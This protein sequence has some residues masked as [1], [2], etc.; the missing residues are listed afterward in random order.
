MSLQALSLPDMAG[1]AVGFLLTVSIFSYLFRDNA[2]FR[3]AI[4]LFIGVAAGLAAAI[5]LY[6]V[7][8]PRLI[9][10]LWSAKGDLQD[11]LLLLAPVVLVIL[12][13]MKTSIRTSAWGSPVMAF[14]TGVG[15]A[16]A[17]G[18]AVLG[19]L[20]PQA[21]A[22]INVF[23]AQN[24]QLG[25]PGAWHEYLTAI[26]LLVVTIATLI[27]FQFGWRPVLHQ[28]ARE[29]TWV[30]GLTWVGKVTISVTL[31]VIFAGILIAS[32]SGLVER[33]DFLLST[34]LSLIGL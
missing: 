21:A 8:W 32:M 2:L 7:I 28:E 17:V 10:P 25:L 6:N 26:F 27:Y 22:S 30:D 5:S 16:T 14:L 4:H 3:L 24:V 33:I 23:E 18:G 11:W 20:L 9:K 13:L 1:T 12:L 19:T 34:L 31:G 29:L 15:A